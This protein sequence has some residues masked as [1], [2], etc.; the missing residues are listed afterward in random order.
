MPPT[1]G[2]TQCKGMRR[3]AEGLASR[4]SLDRRL[5]RPL[6]RTPAFPFSRGSHLGG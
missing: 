3:W 4:C 2:M 5:C 1:I 6:G